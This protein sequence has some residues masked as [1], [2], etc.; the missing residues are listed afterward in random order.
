V[1]LVDDDGIVSGKPAVTTDLGEQQA[2]GHHLDGGRFRHSVGEAHRKANLLA[3]LDLELLGDA[4]RGSPG[5]DAPRL[6]VADHGLTAEAGPQADF[7]QLGGLAG[8][9]FASHDHHLA[10]R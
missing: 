6:G 5:G 3:E 10:K 1:G 2:V 7:R 4:P 8:A 9:G